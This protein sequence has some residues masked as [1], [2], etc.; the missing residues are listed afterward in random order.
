MFGVVSLLQS[1]SLFQSS[2]RF[3]RNDLHLPLLTFFN[4]INFSYTV[5][6]DILVASLINS[7]FS[8]HLVQGKG[9]SGIFTN[10]PS[11]FCYQIMI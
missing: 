2:S 9:V 8:V 7:P 1:Q 11:L 5:T 6:L 3:S 4:F 10:V